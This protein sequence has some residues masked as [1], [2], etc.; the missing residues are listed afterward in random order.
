MP[1]RASLVRVRG[2]RRDRRLRASAG[3][4]RG[5]RARVPRASAACVQ[6]VQDAR[7]LVG[8]DDDLLA[9]PPVADLGLVGLA[10]QLA[11]ASPRGRCGPRAGRR[12][13]RRA[14]PPPRG[15]AS[16]AGSS[17]RASGANGSSPTPRAGRQDRSPSSA[18]RG[19][20]DRDRRRARAPR[21]SR[22]FWPPE[23]VFTRASRFSSSPTSRTTSSTVARLRVVAGEEA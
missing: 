16:S 13:G 8:A 5:L 22:R 3:A 2:Q 15:S 10:S 14:A 6:L 11:G 1:G 20:R 23:S 4:P 7:R 19:R 18:R 12:R 9:V 17:F 21:S